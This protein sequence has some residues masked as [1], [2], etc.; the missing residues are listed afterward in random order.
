MKLLNFIVHCFS[1]LQVHVHEPST[2]ELFI[3]FESFLV[4]LPFLNYKITI[5]CLHYMSSLSCVILNSIQ[6]VIILS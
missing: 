4:V 5:L 2:D 3:L 1:V 6:S